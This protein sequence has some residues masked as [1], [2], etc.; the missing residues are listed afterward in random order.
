MIKWDS[1]TT[2]AGVAKFKDNEVEDET[3]SAMIFAGE[4]LKN[5][6]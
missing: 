1:G 6:R 3:T 4:L 2:I 5:A